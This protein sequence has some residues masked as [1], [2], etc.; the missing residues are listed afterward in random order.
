VISWFHAFV[1]KFNMHRY[2]TG[3]VSRDRGFRAFSE[4]VGTLKLAP[5]LSGAIMLFAVTTASFNRST[6]KLFAADA[7]AQVG[8]V[9]GYHFSP[10][11]FAS[12]KTRSIDGSQCGAC[13]RQSDAPGE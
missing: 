5:I 1:S 4:C 2:I 12:V 10:R 6:G 7:K 9:G 3:N 13:N 11:H 8:R